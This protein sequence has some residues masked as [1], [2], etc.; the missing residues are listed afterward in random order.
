MKE[1]P[2]FNDFSLF[3]CGKRTE[4]VASRAKV[5]GPLRVPLERI[6][7]RFLKEPTLPAYLKSL[8]AIDSEKALWRRRRSPK[9]EKPAKVRV[10][11]LQELLW[12]PDIFGIGIGSRFAFI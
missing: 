4:P 5:R 8:I 6:R 11:L 10:L 2:S 3:R 7:S 9:R 1:F 12:D